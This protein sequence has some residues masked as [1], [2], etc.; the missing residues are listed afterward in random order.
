[1]LLDTKQAL[2]DAGIGY[3]DKDDTYIFEKDG[4]RIAF[5]GLDGV[6]WSDYQADG[7]AVVRKIKSLKADDSISAVI[8]TLHAGDEYGSFHSQAQAKKAYRLINAGADLIIGAHP[9]VVQGM[10][11]YNGRLILYSIGNFVFGGNARVRAMETMIPRIM[12]KFSDDKELLGIQLRLYPANVSGDTSG[13]N[14]DNNYQ[15]VL[16]EGRQAKDIFYMVSR[17]STKKSAPVLDTETDQYRDYQ[18]IDI[19]PQKSG[20]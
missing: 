10:E 15:P 5:V 16:V 3:F 18:W 19:T 12:L 7:D 17:D 1:G 11:L 4:I 6:T 14:Y 2:S 13:G 20:D 9:H 8:A